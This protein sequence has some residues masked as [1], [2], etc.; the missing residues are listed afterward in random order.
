VLDGKGLL[1]PPC[2]LPLP[3]SGSRISYMGV[4][5]EWSLRCKAAK[6]NPEGPVEPLLKVI[7]IP[8]WSPASILRFLLAR[9]G[10]IHRSEPQD[11]PRKLISAVQYPSHTLSRK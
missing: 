3:G 6:R 7:Y 9:I 1:I 4:G 8:G 10:V 5:R 2:I 11:A